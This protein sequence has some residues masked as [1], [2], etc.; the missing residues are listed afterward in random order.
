MT[1]K[2]LA[3]SGKPVTIEAEGLL[4]VCLCHEIDHLNGVIFVDKM[5]REITEDEEERD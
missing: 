3:R 4:A 5:T 1:V 2:A